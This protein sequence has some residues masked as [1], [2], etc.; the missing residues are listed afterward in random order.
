MNKKIDEA[1]DLLE[2]MAL[3]HYKWSS[4]IGATQTNILGKCDVNALDIIIVKPD[5]LSQKFNKIHVNALATQLLNG[6]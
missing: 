6:S 4:E 5:A 1:Y 3:N 2:N